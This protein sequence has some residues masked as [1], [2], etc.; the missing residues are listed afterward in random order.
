MWKTSV[1][2]K[3]KVVYINKFPTKSLLEATLQLSWTSKTNQWPSFCCSSDFFEIFF[4]LKSL[5]ALYLLTGTFWKIWQIQIQIYPLLLYSC[6]CM[7]V[8][9]IQY[10]LFGNLILTLWPFSQYMRNYNKNTPVQASPSTGSETVEDELQQVDIQ[11]ELQEQVKL[12]W[13]CGSVL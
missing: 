1:Q 8:V 11:Q 6:S 2:Q 5:L 3:E 7:M 9:S 4:L 12:S 10:F 13:K